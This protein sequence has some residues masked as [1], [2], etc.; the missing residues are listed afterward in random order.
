M[1]SRHNLLGGLS[2]GGKGQANGG[3]SSKALGRDD[4]AVA[5]LTD[6][7]HEDYVNFSRVW[8]QVGLVSHTACLPT[9]SR[10]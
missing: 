2:E 5:V 8:R 6:L 10:A 7:G 1:L 9:T 3:S 4:L